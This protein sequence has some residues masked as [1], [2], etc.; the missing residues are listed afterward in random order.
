MLTAPSL[1]GNYHDDSLHLLQNSEYI[2]QLIS[3]YSN[4]EIQGNNRFINISSTNRGIITN[5][6]IREV[7]NIREPPP[8]YEYPPKYQL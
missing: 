2:N 5:D 7:Y 4:Q 3:P 8:A 1:N 6:L